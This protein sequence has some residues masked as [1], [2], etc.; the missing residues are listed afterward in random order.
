MIMMGLIVTCLVISG[1][2]RLAMQL[3]CSVLDV[4]FYFN[5]FYLSGED[6]ISQGVTELNFLTF[7]ESC[8][9]DAATFLLTRHHVQPELVFPA[10][11]MTC[12]VP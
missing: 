11:F 8:R 4:L 10:S 12:F 2:Q 5:W 1:S 3:S 6:V 9:K 7:R